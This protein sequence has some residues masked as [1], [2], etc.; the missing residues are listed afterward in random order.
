[1]E[2]PPP[3]SVEDCIKPV[4]TRG[5]CTAHYQRVRAFGDPQAWKPVQLRNQRCT[6]A[7]CTRQHVAHGYCNGHLLR[8]EKYGDPRAHEP[9]S[10]LKTGRFVGRDGYVH[11]WTG[12]RYERE[13]RVVMTRHLGRPLKSHETVHHRNG[14]RADNR[15]ENLELWLGRH[16]RGQS[17]ADRIA[18]AV[19]LL[20]EHAPHRLKES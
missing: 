3:C 11:I 8:V 6:V 20:R 17:L 4:V 1:M 12:K 13:H 14:D 19:E 5:Y 16:G 7:G 2:A 15:I 10:R 18:D 9:I